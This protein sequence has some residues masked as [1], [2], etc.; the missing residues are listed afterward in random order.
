MTVLVDMVV[1]S[2]NGM[3][4]FFTEDFRGKGLDRGVFL[5]GVE[6]EA[7]FAARLL[8]ERDAVPVVFDRNLWK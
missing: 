7:G 2:P 1:M 6:W 4:L 8:E 5:P 3:S